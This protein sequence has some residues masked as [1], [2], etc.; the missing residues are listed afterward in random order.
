MLL[1]NVGVFHFLTMRLD[2]AEKYYQRAISLGDHL[3]TQENNGEHYRGAISRLGR[4]AVYRISGRVEL[5]IQECLE[6]Q[7]SLQ[8]M[9]DKYPNLLAHRVEL[10]RTNQQLGSIYTQERRF[11]E[12]EQTLKQGLADCL[13]LQEKHPEHG[14]TLANLQFELGHLYFLLARFEESERAFRR[15]RDYFEHGAIDRPEAVTFTCRLAETCDALG[16]VYGAMN[17]PEKEKELLQRALD[18]WTEGARKFPAIPH[19]QWGEAMGHVHVGKRLAREGYQ[20]LALGQ[21]ETATA[22][23]T[24]LA[25]QYSQAVDYRRD[26]ADAKIHLARTYYRRQRPQ[27]SLQQLDD[28]LAIRRF[29]VERYPGDRRYATALSNSHNRRGMVRLTLGHYSQALAEFEEVVRLKPNSPIGHGW[30]ARIAA[31]A[32]DE[33]VRDGAR[34]VEAA[35]RA[36]ELT[37]WANWRHIA[38]LAAAYAELGDFADAVRY[39]RLA[40]DVSADDEQD[41]LRLRDRFYQQQRPYREEFKGETGETKSAFVLAVWEMRFNQGEDALVE[42]IFGGSSDGAMDRSDSW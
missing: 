20:L 5:A 16:L 7:Q 24:R 39:N 6:A 18:L 33:A 2:I 32:P 34:A 11:D 31:T 4:G 22:I 35:T 37:E 30:I 8:R 26:L 3:A 10:C 1:H 14:V 28:E 9:V 25:E 13:V 15:A 41:N 40:I 27:E 23:L 38:S 12:A 42:R 19:L 36:C 17:R 21:F 29:F